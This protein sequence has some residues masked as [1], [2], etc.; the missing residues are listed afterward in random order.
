MQTRRGWVALALLGMV[1]PGAAPAEGET[2][3]EAGLATGR[4]LFVRY[5]ASCHG[6]L[7]RG[8]VPMSFVFRERPPDLTRIAARRGGWF[9]ELLVTEIV[10]GRY[11][12]HG[13]RAMPVWGE[14]LRRS[15]LALVVEYLDALQEPVH[16]GRMLYVRYC[17]SCHG[18]DGRG[19]AS[20]AEA[21]AERPP[22]LT[23]LARRHE[24]W[25]PERGVQEVV[26]GR[27]A[28]H[29]TRKMPVWGHL[30]TRDELIVL[31]EYLERIQ[32][33]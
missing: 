26:D 23:T 24:G 1:L 7:G 19:D 22:D 25:F 33:P 10:D 9:P 5:C 14:W 13:G 12:A 30:L 11:V 17:Q 4:T 32:E 8:D 20:V 16:P 2:E 27:H 15:E 31:S 28:A 6:E 21:L 3:G 18:P 29:G